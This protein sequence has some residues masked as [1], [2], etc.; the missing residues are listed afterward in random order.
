MRLSG[1]VWR[2]GCRWG[3][4]RLGDYVPPQQEKQI[5]PKSPTC[6]E[7][8]QDVFEGKKHIYVDSKYFPEVPPPE[9]EDIDYGM[10]DEDA[11]E[12][13]LEDVGDNL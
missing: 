9:Y 2:Y 7:S 3:V 13:V 8:L 6:K 10:D 4:D 5:V 1:S 12:A 11:A